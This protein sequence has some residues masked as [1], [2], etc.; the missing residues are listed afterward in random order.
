MPR[1]LQSG[2]ARRVLGRCA[3][4]SGAT[5]S[6]RNRGGLL[7]TLGGWA[8]QTVDVAGDTNNGVGI[9]VLGGPR[10]ARLGALVGI[11]DRCEIGGRTLGPVD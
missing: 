9:V 11:W 3:L 1:P 7:G 4:G 5:A 8:W 2:H 6:G 10:L